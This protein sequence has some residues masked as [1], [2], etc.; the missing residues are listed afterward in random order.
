MDTVG[1]TEYKVLNDNNEDPPTVYGFGHSAVFKDFI[2]A[3]ESNHEPLVSGEA[4]RK[5]LE[6]IMAIYK[7]QRTGL[8][9]DL[10]CNFSTMDMYGNAMRNIY[11]Y[12]Y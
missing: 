6:I 10:P 11:Q 9:V 7:S 4:G 8:P 12:E 3:I 5:S 1:D 2:D